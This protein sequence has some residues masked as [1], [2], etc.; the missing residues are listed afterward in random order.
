MADRS[1]DVAVSASRSGSDA[2]GA[3]RRIDGDWC[4][5]GL[6]PNVLLARGA[7]VETSYSFHRFRSRRDPAIT[8]GRGAS[9]YLGTTF[10][11]GP[12]GSVTIG[13]YAML[14]AAQLSIDGH[15]EIGDHALVSWGVVVMDGY[16]VPFTPEGRRRLGET[17]RDPFTAEA[18]DVRPVSIGAAVWIGFGCTILPGVSIGEGAVVAARSVVAEDV[19]AGCVV[20]G[21]PAGIVRRV[22]DAGV[23][24]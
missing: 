10:D 8:F 22:A 6:P 11:L 16:R 3:R 21:N 19:P 4:D 15:L 20:A 13:D 14:N 2:S 17:G 18:A 24:L 5:L 9:A 1:G 12:R 23:G 7:H